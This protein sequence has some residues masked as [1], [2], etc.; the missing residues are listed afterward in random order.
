MTGWLVIDE[1]ERLW[2]EEIVAKFKG[3]TLAFT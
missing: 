3:A 2:K 1:L